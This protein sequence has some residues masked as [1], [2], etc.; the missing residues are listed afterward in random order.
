[1]KLDALLAAIPLE[2][3]LLSTLS[4]KME[5]ILPLCLRTLLFLALFFHELARTPTPKSLDPFAVVH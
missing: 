4:A 2:E 5:H 3:I 1:M